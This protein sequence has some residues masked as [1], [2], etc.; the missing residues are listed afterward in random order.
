MI[1]AN[2]ISLV[3][4]LLFSVSALSGDFPASIE[5]PD[6]IDLKN[7]QFLATK[8]KPMVVVFLSAKCPCS[9]SHINELNSLSKEFSNFNFV[10]VHSNIDED[11]KLAKEYFILAKLAFPI[12][13]DSSHKIADQFKALKTP[14]SFVI[15]SQGEAL[16]RGGVS[17]SSDC[18]KAEKLYLRL[19]LEDI[20]QNRPVK[21]AMGRALG[22]NIT[23]VKN[24]VW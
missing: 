13:S 3:L 8:D 6:L 20:K 1:R 14:H 22:C 17:D 24:N 10:A 7:L 15:N 18:S 2:F 23:R 16:Y 12:I 21:V 9:N 4:C 5:G 19:A 11:K